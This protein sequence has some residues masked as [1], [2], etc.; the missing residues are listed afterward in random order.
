[1]VRRA[2]AAVALAAAGA[3]FALACGP[4]RAEWMP[5]GLQPTRTT[6]AEV[7]A[8]NARATGPPAPAFARRR[9][10]WTYA[11]RALRLSVAV[12]VK[13]DDF[14]AD[15]AL[16]GVPYAAGRRHGVG[17]RA[18]G[19]GIAHATL[20]D[21]QGDA[22]DRLPQSPFGW[23]AADCAL[24]GETRGADPAWV[25]ED[26]PPRDKPH[27]F[28]VDEA[29]GLIVREVTREGARTVVTAF[30][31]FE[32]SAGGLRPRRWHVADGDPEHAL[33]VTV[34]TFEPAALDDAAV[35]PPPPRRVFAPPAPSAA[36]LVLPARFDGQR[37]WVDV[38]LG[39]PRPVPFVLDTGTA[40]IVLDRGLAARLGPRPALE[41]A[42]VPRMAAG[43]FAARDVSVLALP[44]RGLA[45]ILGYDFFFGHVVR[46][47]YPHRR[48]EVW[49]HDSADAVFADPRTTVLAANVAEGLPLVAAS[50]GPAGGTRFALDTGSDRLVVLDPFERR[51]ASEI[52]A[53]WS[54]ARFSRGS[55]TDTLTY[56][57]GS[58][59]AQ[60]RRV[61]AFSLGA[62]RLGPATVAAQ[63]ANDRPDA[64][65]IPLDGIVGTDELARFDCWFDYDDGRIGLRPHG[66]ADELR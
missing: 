54:P 32:P 51:N 65:D 49:P 4:A 11:S 1:M 42:S 23:S 59:R 8:A 48:V 33:D 6:L 44:L 21:L 24:A 26:R 43:A 56:L 62:L 41:H 40:S 55:E 36:A 35:A 38:D 2:R 58:V 19:N 57:E 12:A 22:L 17:W 3:W 9:E 50:I 25:I 30:E 27:W 39:L 66:A 28:F 46:I 7:L 34:D 18:D 45:G 53:H 47:D 16:G 60:A 61:A 13:G 37:V 52:A 10:R 31:R 63:V 14:R 15:I 64:L 29:S 5:P 20:S